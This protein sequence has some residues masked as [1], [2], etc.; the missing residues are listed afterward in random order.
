MSAWA[1]L[2]APTTTAVWSRRGS[3]WSI[4]SPSSRIVKP[5][6]SPAADSSATPWSAASGLVTLTRISC[7]AGLR[8]RSGVVS[9]GLCVGI[10]EPVLEPGRAEARVIGGQERPLARRD[11][12]VLR[13]RV[14]DDLP[15]I[16]A[17][18]QHATDELVEAELL[19]A[20]D[21]D[22]AVQRGVNGDPGEC[23]GDV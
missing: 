18:R 10:S 15:G 14:G 3:M 9:Q 11:P 7:M 13:V 16:A 22:D 5:I 6:D 19:G 12:E 4:R 2:R 1:R 21:L 8:S 23:A 20:G 17:L